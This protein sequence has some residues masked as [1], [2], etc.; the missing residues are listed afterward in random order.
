MRRLVLLITLL[1]MI[2]SACTTSPKAAATV[3]G[4]TITIADIEA[5]IPGDADALDENQVA[6]LL[7]NL[8]ADRLV[9]SE[10]DAEF[11]ITVDPAEFET[12]R[13]ALISQLTAQGQTLEEV[14]EQNEA[15]EALLDIVVSQQ[16][17]ITDIQEVLLDQAGPPTEEEL[18][19]EFEAQRLQLM[20]V[21]ASHI[22]LETQDAAQGAL[23]RAVG[24]EDFATLAQELSTGPS[25]PEGGDLGCTAPGSYVPEFADAITT[26]EIG[27]PTGPIETQFGFHV[28]LV[29]ERTEANFE[30]SR[31]SILATIDQ[32]RQAELFDTWRTD[33][34]AAAEV[35]VDES[36]GRWVT[37]PVPSV[38]PS[39]V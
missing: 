26:A 21:C 12:E 25:G 6:S 38:V 34:L 32:R 17:L 9:Q 33:A 2:A 27:V 15:T 23:D 36:Y 14:L 7:F 11:S 24:G 8:I 19:L 1:A 18:Q 28:I 20:N 13:T 30:D 39:G 3:N 31:E 29:S 10:A 16:I 37:D 4:D 22:L 5:L 35:E